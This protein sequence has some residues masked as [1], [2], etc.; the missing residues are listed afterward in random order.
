[1]TAG[2]RWWA[3]RLRQFRAHVRAR[4]EPH[5]RAALATW[6]SPDQ[7]RLFDTMH[8]ADRRHGLDVVASLRADGV[9]DGDVLLAGLL[10][11]AGK[12][13]V[14]VMARV[15]YAL[16][17]AYGR[18]LWRLAS[19]APGMRSAIDRLAVHAETSA[20]LAAAAGCPPRTVD[21]IRW[22]ETPRD[23]EFGELLRLADEAN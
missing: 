12:G 15:A 7:L 22:Q 9:E 13:D 18:W 4:V 14:G 5:E 17:Q 19:I 8:L 10:H 3:A 1:V 6:L 2:P 21:L 16:G 23:P 20:G 11:D